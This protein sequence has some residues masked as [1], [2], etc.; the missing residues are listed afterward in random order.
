ME[1]WGREPLSGHLPSQ[2]HRASP[3]RPQSAQTSTKRDTEASILRMCRGPRHGPLMPESNTKIILLLIRRNWSRCSHS[4][5]EKTQQ[6]FQMSSKS[7]FSQE[8]NTGSMTGKCHDCLALRD[9]KGEQKTKKC[10]AGE[11]LLEQMNGSL[12]LIKKKKK[13][14]I[15]WMQQGLEVSSLKKKKN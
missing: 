8:F 6:W 3:R 13:K 9:R 7:I 12:E 5:A 4:W 15:L 14:K 1:W 2:G 11:V 10:D